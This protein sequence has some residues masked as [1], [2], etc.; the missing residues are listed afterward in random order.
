MYYTQHS[1]YVNSV[2]YNS[3]VWVQN[4]ILDSRKIMILRYNESVINIHIQ[5]KNRVGK[6]S[7]TIQVWNAAGQILNIRAWN[8]SIYAYCEEGL[9]KSYFKHLQ[10]SRSCCLQNDS[11]PKVNTSIYG[12]LTGW[13]H[14]AAYFSDMKPLLELYLHCSISSCP[15]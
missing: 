12:F 14:A 5:N 10:F 9:S 2:Q 13:S 11:T 3:K 4:I 15:M 1:Q 8:L 6:H 7:K